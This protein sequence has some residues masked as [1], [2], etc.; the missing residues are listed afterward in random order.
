MLSSGLIESSQTKIKI[1]NGLHFFTFMETKHVMI[2]SQV[3][4]LK[5]YSITE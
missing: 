3:M 4:Y 5:I 2:S 1:V